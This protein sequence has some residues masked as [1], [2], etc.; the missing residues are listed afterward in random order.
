MNERLE[1]TAISRFIERIANTDVQ[2]DARVRIWMTSSN[3]VSYSPLF[4]LGNVKN[5]RGNTRIPEDAAI[6]QDP[7]VGAIE[8]LYGNTHNLY[9]QILVCSGFIGLTLMILF[10]FFSLRRILVSTFRLSTHTDDKASLLGYFGILLSALLIN[11]VVEAHL[12][13]NTQDPFSVLFWFY[14]GISMQLI[15]VYRKEAL[16]KSKKIA[17]VCDTPY[18]IM[19]AVNLTA[20]TR[21]SSRDHTDLFVYKQFGDAHRII[22][23]LRSISIFSAIHE[24]EPYS[25]QPVSYTKAR[26]FFRLLFPKTTLSGHSDL[27]SYRDSAY[28]TIFYSFS[29]HF[30]MNLRSVFN[31]STSAIIEDGISSYVS[32]IEKESSSGSMRFFKRYIMAGTLDLSAERAYFNRPELATNDIAEDLCALP[33]LTHGNPAIP[34]IKKVFSYS[35]DGTYNFDPIVYLTQPLEEMSGYIADSDTK[36]LARLQQEQIKDFIIRVHPRMKHFESNG[37]SVDTSEVMWELVCLEEIT[38]NHLLI[39]CFS[40]AAIMPKLLYDKEPYMIFTYKLFFQN[41]ENEFW[42]GVESFLDKVN[43]LYTKRHAIY[44]PDSL[45]ELIDIVKRIKHELS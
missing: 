25:T 9:I 28:R 44:I 38:D 39:S 20:N 13:F 21:K 17:I 18:Q 34:L 26:T 40:T 32:D 31:D 8:R 27:S 2:S 30:T 45:D 16:E 4:G 41:P 5:I 15:Q 14:L 29:T 23:N 42:S 36:L 35:Q 6:L 43:N 24:V 33:A 11:G 37:I 3:L 10:L 12:L 22:E 7:M 1:H 19:N